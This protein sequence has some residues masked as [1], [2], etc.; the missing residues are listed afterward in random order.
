MNKWE[1]EK[2]NL[3]KLISQNISYEEIGRQYG[4]TGANIKKQAKKLGIELPSRRKINSK[5]TFNKKKPETLICLGCGKSFIKKTNS[6]GK[7]CSI[8]C[9][10]DYEHYEWIKRWKNGEE[11]GIVGQYG[12]SSHLRRFLFEKYNSKCSICGWGETNPHTGTI[13]L[14]VE[15]IDGN[16]QNNSED[17]LTLLC[18]NCHSLTSTYKG[19]NKGNGRKERSK[20]NL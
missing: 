4:C 11:T 13:P 9:Q 14:E 8:K 20:Y 1:F 15:H 19:A 18:P 5:E 16:Y 10:R 12:I 17:N 3:E 6:F 2:E 7:Y